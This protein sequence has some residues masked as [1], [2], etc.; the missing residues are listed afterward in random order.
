MQRIIPNL[1]GARCGD[2]EQLLRICSF[3]S[4]GWGQQDGGLGLL[5]VAYRVAHNP[6]HQKVVMKCCRF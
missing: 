1:G 6:T 5:R 2:R 4:F 3:I